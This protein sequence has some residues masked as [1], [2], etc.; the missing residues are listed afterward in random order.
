MFEAASECLFYK[1]EDLK[2]MWAL[3]WSAH[4]RFFKCMCIAAKVPETIGVAKRPLED[5]KCVVIGLQ[6]T[7]EAFMMKELEDS[8]GCLDGFVSTAK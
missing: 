6:S 4:Q 3:F 5:G 2:T 8:N 7:G 1:K